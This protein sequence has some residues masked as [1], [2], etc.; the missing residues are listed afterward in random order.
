MTAPTVTLSG[1]D[2]EGSPTSDSSSIIEEPTETPYPVVLTG[3][4]SPEVNIT[5]PPS[6]TAVG[7]SLTLFGTATGEQFASY[8]FA[9]LGPESGG[10]WLPLSEANSS[11]IQDGILA[12]FSFDNLPT[13]VYYVRLSAFN[14]E[15]A[16]IGQCVIELLVG[17]EPS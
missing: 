2:F 15:G 8:N 6:G 14:E 9:F 1:P 13:G 12:T 11:P 5:S 7:S 17:L 3:D 16:V 10:S 4:C